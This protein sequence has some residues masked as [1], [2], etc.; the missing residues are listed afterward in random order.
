MP[1]KKK[2]EV[3]SEFRGKYYFLS[4]F[5]ACDLLWEGQVWKTTEHVF[6][7]MKT[8]SKSDREIIRKAP[9]PGVAKRLGRK[10]QLRED[11]EEEKDEV[12]YQIVLQKF[13][14][15]KDLRKALIATGDALLIE[16][17]TWGDFYWGMCRGEGQ[18]KLGHILMRVRKEVKDAG[19]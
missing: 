7:A 15:N 4:N 8:D 11:W 16:G 3:I 9:S 18:N 13:K 19:R 10:V 2:Q 6:Q 17:N 14:Q 1:K 12:M 5:Y